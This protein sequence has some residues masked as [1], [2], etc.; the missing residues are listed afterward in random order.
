MLKIFEVLFQDLTSNEV[1][2]CNW[3]GYGDLSKH[4][5]GEGDL[6]L[7][8]PLEEKESFENIAKNAGFRKVISYQANHKYLEHYYGLDLQT[9]KFAHVHVYFKIVTGEHISKNYVLPIDNYLIRNIENSTVI[10]TINEKAKLNIFL[11]RYFIKIG[12]FLG[13][14]QYFREYSKYSEEWIALESDQELSEVAELGLSKE[15]LND[16]RDIYLGSNAVDKFLFSLALKRKLRGYK[17]KTY[18]P[19]LIY[20]F[21]SIFFRLLNKVFIKNKKMFQPGFVIA[22]CG[23]DGSGKSSLVQSLNNLFSMHFSLKNFHLGRPSSTILTFFINPVIRAYSALRRLNK[24]DREVRQ[25][26]D[27]KISV[28]FILRSIL[29]A[30]DRKQEA[31]RAHKHASKGYI[32]ICDRYPGILEGKMD[33]PRIPFTADKG[34]IYNFFYRLENKLY[35]SIQPAHAIYQLTVPLEISIER[36]NLRDKFGK[37]TEQELRERFAINQDAVFLSEIYHPI[38]ATLPIEKVKFEVTKMIWQQYI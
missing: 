31:K 29:L 6:D 34:Q 7:F 12:S 28:I 15:L 18:L 26:R 38:D 37:E 3:K 4:L 33:S 19:N 32:V 21:S 23:L 27:R 10:P 20:T 14:I 17:R 11:I 1:L 16:M 30:Y 36:N 8:V 22:I 25:E 13:F 5:N 35:N 24:K 2:V 9:L